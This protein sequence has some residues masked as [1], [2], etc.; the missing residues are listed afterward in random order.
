MAGVDPPAC[1][2]DGL[3]LSDT[4]VDHLGLA[5]EFHQGLIN[6]AYDG[7]VSGFRVLGFRAMAFG[8]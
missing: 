8:V 5:Q 6:I 3:S 2:A 7:E 1:Y 4:K